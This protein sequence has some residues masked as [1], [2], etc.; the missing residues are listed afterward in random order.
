M[1]EAD[2][3]GWLKD[4]SRRA[5]NVPDLVPGAS[6]NYFYAPLEASAWLA[7]SQTALHGIF[8]A[9]HALIGAW[10]AIFERAKTNIIK[11][12]AGDIDLRQPNAKTHFNAAIGVMDA[13]VSI[14][15]AGRLRTM[16]DGIQAQTVSE[17]LEQAE[18]LLAARHTVAAAVLAGGALE[19]HLLHLC[20]RN[21]LTWPGEGSIS[22]YD[23]AISQARNAGTVEV[24]GVTDTKLVGG[25]G[26]LRN[27]AAHDPTNFEHTPGEVRLMIDGIRLFIVRVP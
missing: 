27:D 13:A 24:Y 26:G 7:E 10:T 22:K 5:R 14:L 15:E 9:G 8:P 25:W 3:L 12:P 19:T 4:L 21:G 17:V 11:G 18:G 2:A 6:I 1:N 23:Q 16:L 20:R